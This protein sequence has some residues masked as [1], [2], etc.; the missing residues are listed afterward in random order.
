[1]IIKDEELEVH[2]FLDDIPPDL[3]ETYSSINI[4]QFKDWPAGTLWCKEYSMDRIWMPPTHI[5]GRNGSSSSSAASRF[6]Y[7]INLL[8]V[9]RKEGW[10]KVYVYDG[11]RRVHANRQNTPLPPFKGHWVDVPLYNA[12]SFAWLEDASISPYRK[13]RGRVIAPQYWGRV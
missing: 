10:N 2:L 3:L 1:M 6:S 5:E 8:L 13:S 7:S 9:Y 11:S 4:C 12:A